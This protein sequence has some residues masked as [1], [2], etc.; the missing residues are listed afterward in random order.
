MTSRSS[1]T[2]MARIV[3]ASPGRRVVAVVRVVLGL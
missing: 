3:L 1:H 2:T